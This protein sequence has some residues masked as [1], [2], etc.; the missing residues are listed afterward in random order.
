MTLAIGMLCEDGLILAT[1][2]RISTNG[3][4]S[5]GIKLKPF[6]A[7]EGVYAVAHS[8]TDVNAAESLIAELK[9]GLKANPLESLGAFIDEVKKRMNEWSSAAHVERPVVQLLIVLFV[10]QEWGFYFCE[11]PNTVTF[12]HEKYR[13]IGEGF[14]YTDP[15]YNTWFADGPLVSPHAALCRISYMMH[16]AKQLLPGT[17]GGKTDVAVLFRG[18]DKPRLINREDMAEAEGRGIILDRLVSRFA[19]LVMT[20]TTRGAEAISQMAEGIFQNGLHYATKEFRCQF[21]DKTI[22]H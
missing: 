21:P 3:W 7:G 12:I 19:S 22:R 17:V 10:K 6:E 13:A 4:V 9:A 18:S 14:M 1:D 20:G 16:T 8:S 5:D 15:I 11:P 2:T